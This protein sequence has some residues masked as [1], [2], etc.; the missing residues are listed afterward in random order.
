MLR[1]DIYY[2]KQFT[3]FWVDRVDHTKSVP[4]IIAGLGFDPRSMQ[5][6]KILC[7][8]KINPKVLPIKFSVLSSG[9][10]GNSGLDKATEKNFKLLSQFN[11]VCEPIEVDMFDTQNRP[12]GGRQ[13]VQKIYAEHNHFICLSG[14]FRGDRKIYRFFSKLL[15]NGTKPERKATTY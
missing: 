14:C 4:L 13:I 11:A 10:K 8:N 7:S 3:K 9:A 2:N 1:K 12:I 15:E 5:S 6:A